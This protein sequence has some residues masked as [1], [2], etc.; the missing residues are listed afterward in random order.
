MC[1]IFRKMCVE[2]RGKMKIK[3]NKSEK[4]TKEEKKERK[5]ENKRK[6]EKKGCV[7]GTCCGPAAVLLLFRALC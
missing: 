7:A 5:R 3:V 6:Q 4:S 1:I 2:K